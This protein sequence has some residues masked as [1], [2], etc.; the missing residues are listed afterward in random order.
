MYDRLS[1]TS[2]FAFCGQ[3]PNGNLD[4]TLDFLIC[5]QRAND[6]FA[7]TLNI[8]YFAVKER[9]AVWEEL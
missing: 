5:C 9:M 4:A 1:T 8:S 7:T 6:R 2:N 3:K